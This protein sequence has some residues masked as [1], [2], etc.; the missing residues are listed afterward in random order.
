MDVLTIPEPGLRQPARSLRGVTPSMRNRDGSLAAW[1]R[2]P[3]VRITAVPCNH[4]RSRGEQPIERNPAQASEICRQDPGRG[5]RTLP[6]RAAPAGTSSPPTPPAGTNT[7]AAACGTPP[8]EASTRSP[9]ATTVTGGSD[10]I[11]HLRTCR[12]LRRWRPSLRRHVEPRPRGRPG[13]SRH[14]S[15]GHPPGWRN[16]TPIGN[17]PTLIPVPALQGRSTCLPMTC[18]STTSLMTWPHD[19]WLQ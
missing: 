7:P 15:P 8:C 5:A 1:L 2:P 10:R 6:P 17:L 18:G 11:P 16:P 9:P 13:R 4:A 19:R 14:R 3:H 12:R